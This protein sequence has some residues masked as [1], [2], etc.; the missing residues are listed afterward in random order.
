MERF[1][2]II[3]KVYFGLRENSKNVLEMGSH[4]IETFKI[5]IKYIQ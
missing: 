3:G 5:T 2:N 1:I 4:Q